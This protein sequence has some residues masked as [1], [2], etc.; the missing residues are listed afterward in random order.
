MTSKGHSRWTWPRIV[1]GCALTVLGILVALD[2]WADIL[3]IATR[4]EESSHIFLVPLVAGYLIWVRRRR[5]RHLQVVGAWIGPLVVAFGWACY[6][7]GDAHLWQSVWQ[8]G[9][10][11]IACGCFLTAFGSRV[12][13]R[14]I[15]AFFVLV[16]LVPVPGRVRQRIALP[17]ENATARVTQGIFEL[18]DVQVTRSGNLLKINGV[19]VAVAEAC[20]G[21]RMVFALTLVCYAFAFGNP[22]RLYARLL[23]LAASPIAAIL[24]NVIRLVPTVYVYGSFSSVVADR[25]H[26]FS[27]WAMLF[28][29]FLM[30]MGI[31]KLLRWALI[32]IHQFTLAYD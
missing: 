13:I 23:I 32:P 28:A 26:A 10:I 2:A 3:H 9:A 19:E 6:R 29:A 7:I 4:D 16:F 17:M 25:F 5:L 12:L 1:A 18:T 22:L 21:L 15:P 14:L 11:L 27:G 30:L 31:L 20:N 24:C 8:G